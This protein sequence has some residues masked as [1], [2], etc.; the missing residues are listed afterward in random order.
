[1][2]SCASAD[3]TSADQQGDGICVEPI[4]PDIRATDARGEPAPVDGAAAPSSG[5]LVLLD[6]TAACSCKTLISRPRQLLEK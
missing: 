6:A 4:S 1:V 5:I 2:P 3:R